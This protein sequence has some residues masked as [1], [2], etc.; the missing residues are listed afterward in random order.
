MGWGVISFIFWA[1]PLI[2]KA[3]EHSSLLDESIDMCFIFLRLIAWEEFPDKESVT[4]LFEIWG[5][6]RGSIYF[7]VTYEPNYPYRCYILSFMK[8]GQLI[9]KLRIGGGAW[10]GNFLYFPGTAANLNVYWTFLI[11]WK[12]HWY[13]FKF[14]TTNSLWGV[15]RQRKHHGLIWNLGVGEGVNLFFHS[16]WAKISL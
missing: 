5:W 6:G 3:I 13:V 1:P 9:R 2:W 8:I 14:S 15:P 7:F 12:I 11:T 10:G 4:D 16:L